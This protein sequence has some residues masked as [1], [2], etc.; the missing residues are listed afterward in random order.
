MLRRN[1]PS[2]FLLLLLPPDVAVPPALARMLD[3]PISAW[4]AD[5]RF[6]VFGGLGTDLLCGPVW[7]DDAM[8]H[9]NSAQTRQRSVFTKTK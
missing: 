2:L 7:F 4:L 6:L 3:S 8:R 5:Q 9:D 1:S